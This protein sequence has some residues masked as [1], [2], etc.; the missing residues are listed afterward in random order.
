MPQFLNLAGRCGAQQRNKWL[1]KLKV[2]LYT[3]SFFKE[4]N[5][6][7]EG[8][9]FSFVPPLRLLKSL[10]T[11]SQIYALTTCQHKCQCMDLNGECLLFSFAQLVTL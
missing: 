4:I 7:R 1:A 6:V 9:I 3:F 8:A 2:Y 10:D 11:F 5:Y